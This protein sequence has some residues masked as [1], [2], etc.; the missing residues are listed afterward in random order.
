MLRP[1][2]LTL[3]TDLGRPGHA[4]L[5]VPRS[6]ALDRPALRLANRLVGNPEGYAGFEVLLGGLE[7]RAE[8]GCSVAVTGPPVPAWQRRPDGARWAVGSHCAVHLAAGDH[9][10]LAV[11]D[12]GLRNYLALA[13]GLDLPMVLGSR[14]T[15]LLSGLGPPPVRAG[16]RLPLGEPGAPPPDGG[17]VP[18]SVPPSLLPVPVLLGPRDDWF[19]DP[20]DA[21]RGTV[22]TVGSSSN[23]VGLRLEG[24]ALVRTAERDGVELPSEPMLPGAIQVPPSGQPVVFLADGPT[25]GGYP[26]IAVVPESWLPALA[27]ARPGSRVRFRPH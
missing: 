25:T 15:D 19:N 17:P 8:V 21:L 5:G 1:G 20:A 4:H 6:G 2:A 11:P 26:V 10:R 23:R 24:P 13:G 12:A 16:D 7:L 9:L 27:Q 18:V 22:W 14:G 3:V